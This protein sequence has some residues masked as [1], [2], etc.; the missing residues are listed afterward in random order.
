[1]F[2]AEQK[3]EPLFCARGGVTKRKAQR[4]KLISL[5]LADLGLRSP[6][7]GSAA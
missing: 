7:T 4:G 2:N 5:S 3:Q 1:M 6:W